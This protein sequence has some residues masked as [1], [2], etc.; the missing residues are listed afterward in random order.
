ME[1]TYLITGASSG[2]G[3]YIFET[4]VD[5]GEDVYGTCYSSNFEGKYRNRI[6]RVDVADYEQ[7]TNWISCINPSGNIVL[8]NCAGIS[9]NAFTHK[10]SPDKWA[11]VIN[12][13]LVGTYHV[14]RQILPHMR[15]NRFGRIINMS[16]VVAQMSVPGTSA[17]AASKSALW[18]LSKALVAENSSLGVTINN[19]NLG[20]INEGIIRD[21]PPKMLEILKNDIPVGHLGT[22]VNVLQTIKYIIDN[23]YL[24][25]A[26]I[27][28][29]GGLF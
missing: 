3:K 2:I 7:V 18:G 15:N 22:S 9:Y 10:S 25:G 8:I 29:N 6:K 19:I 21:V 20:Y 1:L 26:S 4:L 11:N 28:L 27:D 13:N 12:T 16:S 17:Y 5:N 24:N 23:D 14:I